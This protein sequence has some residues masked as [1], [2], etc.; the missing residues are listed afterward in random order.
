[1]DAIQ[2]EGRRRWAGVGGG[3]G[4]PE[5][6]ES[7]SDGGVRRRP[8]SGGLCEHVGC[9]LLFCA[10]APSVLFELVQP[11]ARLAADGDGLMVD[12][13]IGVGSPVAQHGIDGAEKSVRHGDDGALVAM[14]ALYGCLVAAELRIPGS[15]R[16]MGAFDE[17]CAQDRV[18]AANSSAPPFASTLVVAG[19]DPR[20]GGA[21]PGGGEDRHVGSQFDEDCHGRVAADARKG[22]QEPD[23]GLE[24]G[25]GRFDAPLGGRD[26]E[27]VVVQLLQEVVQDPLAVRVELEAQGISESA[28]LLAHVPAQTPTGWS[29]ATRRQSGRRECGDR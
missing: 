1:M 19:T 27:G 14:A 4:S 22:L 2:S 5:S 9:V 20:P 7:G 12:A 16:R 8:V 24:R 11:A 21:V 23:Q 17:N 13:G 25:Q 29:P 10:G 26:P 18:A 28:E 6:A 3:S 15:D